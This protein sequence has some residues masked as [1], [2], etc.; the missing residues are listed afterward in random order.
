V[1]FLILDRQ[2]LWNLELDV[3]RFC[4]AVCNRVSPMIPFE[5]QLV[6]IEL[7]MLVR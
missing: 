2:G 3:T 4:L 1:I 5:T 6:P 7:H